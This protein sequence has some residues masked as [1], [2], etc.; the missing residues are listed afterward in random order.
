MFT[1]TLQNKDIPFLNNIERIIKNLKFKINKRL[2]LKIRLENNTKKGNVKLICDN[3]KL[4]FHIEKSPFNNNRVKAVTSLPYKK[5][6][7]I[8]LIQDKKEIPIIIKV[9]KNE[10]NI[11]SDLDCWIYGD[12]RFPKKEIL[13]FLDT[14]CGNKK[15]FHLEEFLLNSNEKLVMSAFSALIDCE[16][17][18]NW[19]GLKRVIRIR[20]K[21]KNYLQQ[22][23]E[24]LKKYSI[25]S[26]FKKIK[27]NGS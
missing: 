17:S 11:K 20:M 24:L 13:D 22:W 10:I 27:M 5:Y 18:I 14:Y 12:L 9:N 6:Y 2:L 23:H 8:K 26:K 16:G 3:E 7:V 4:N 1:L 15:D 25:Y 19:Y 21:N